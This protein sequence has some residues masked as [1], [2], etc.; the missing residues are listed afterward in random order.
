MP[1]RIVT[2]TL[3]P[4]VDLAC[5]APYIRPTHKIR[6]FN[7]RFDP[8]GGATVAKAA[9]RFGVPFFCSSVTHPGLE[10]VDPWPQ[11]GPW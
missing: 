9:G 11:F 10:A 7:E 4:A 5:T 8:G 3:S 6:S 2:L 1:H